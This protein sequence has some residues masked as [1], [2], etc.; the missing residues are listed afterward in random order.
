MA[1][2]YEY[3]TAGRYDYHIV[4]ML[5]TVAI[6]MLMV[7]LLVALMDI[8]TVNMMGDDDGDGAGNEYSADGGDAGDDCGDGEAYGWDRYLRVLAQRL[9]TIRACP[10]AG[11]RDGCN[12]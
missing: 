11:P 6:V 2:I 4:V 10:V 12:P 5:L 9:C 1:S 8:C 3:K 7:T